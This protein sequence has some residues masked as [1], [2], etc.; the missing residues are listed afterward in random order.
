MRRERNPQKSER[1]ADSYSISTLPFSYR[2]PSH[3]PSNKFDTA[4]PRSFFKNPRR[5]FVGRY[6]HLC[7]ARA[8]YFCYRQRPRFCRGIG[9]WAAFVRREIQTAKSGLAGQEPC[10][11]PSRHQRNLPRSPGI[12]LPHPH[13]GAGRRPGAPRAAAGDQRHR[14]DSMRLLQT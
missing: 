10:P 3:K 11:Q 14:G 1:E 6:A 7:T 13:D 12:E 2:T 5:W 4:V 9:L 8:L